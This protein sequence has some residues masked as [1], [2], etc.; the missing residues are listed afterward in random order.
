MEEDL[1]STGQL[2]T[3]VHVQR[4]SFRPIYYLGCKNEFADEVSRAILDVDPSGGRLGDL[5]AG[6]GSVAAALSSTIEVL[7]ADVQEYSRVLCSAILNPYPIKPADISGLVNRV[8]KNESALLL[9]QCFK[10][11]IDYENQ[12]IDQAEHGN[13][14]PL[15]ELLES[16]PVAAW[17]QENAIDSPLTEVV[18][19][20]VSR[21]KDAQLMNSPNS[22]VSR[23]FGGVYFS[24]SQ[25]VALDSLLSDSNRNQDSADTFVSAVLSTASNIVN[26]VGKQFAQPIRPRNKSGAIKSGLVKVV[27]KDRSL[28]TFAQYESWLHRY[29]DLP[30]SRGKPIVLRKDYLGAIQEHG[31]ELSVLYADPPYTRDHYSRF[32]HVLETMCL[33]DNPVFSKV[34]KNGKLEISRGLYREERYQSE[35]CIRSR[36]PKAFAELFKS[37]S[38][39]RLPL[40]LSYSPH[41][42]GDGTHPRV[43]STEQ[44]LEVANQYYDRVELVSIQGSSHNN[45]NRVGL[46]LKERETAE[47]LVKCFV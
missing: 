15:V 46:K 30:K 17:T 28:D 39:S 19:A 27:R 36:A 41:D 45:L 20:V 5:F 32:Y 2:R 35:F 31:S 12:C 13:A 11:L 47:I 44:I 43:V 16:E 10:P 34:K 38:E 23:M 42:D 3:E 1:T 26:T 4:G 37:A 7:T 29:A 8:K 33:R 21:L 24:F 6:T 18:N 40:V 22:T 9:K 25:A 14:D